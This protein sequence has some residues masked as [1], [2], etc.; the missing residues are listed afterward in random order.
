VRR[1]LAIRQL[2]CRLKGRVSRK[3]ELRM[4]QSW[5]AQY[6]YKAGCLAWITYYKKNA[7][8]IKKYLKY[9][10]CHEKQLKRVMMSRWLKKS[11]STLRKMHA[12]R[13]M[14][15]IKQ[16]KQI[17]N[18]FQTWLA[19]LEFFRLLDQRVLKHSKKYSIKNK[20]SAIST[21]RDYGR[22]SIMYR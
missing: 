14:M 10:K 20:V 18:R 6:L 16:K 22:K 19:E 11:A 12:V 4:A 13:K 9:L 3:R 7:L 8:L 17:R 15:R 2:A 5:H 1:Q 21:L